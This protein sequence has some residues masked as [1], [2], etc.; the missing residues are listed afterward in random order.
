MDQDDDEVRKFTEAE[1]KALRFPGL[2]PEELR[3]FKTA[4]HQ[5]IE[6]G[7]VSLAGQGEEPAAGFVGRDVGEVVNVWF[8]NMIA[9][10]RGLHYDWDPPYWHYDWDPTNWKE[11]DL[12]PMDQY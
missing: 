8:W 3:R 9:K 1:E 5:F 11:V 4:L 7:K 10:W 6:V 12:F 2:D